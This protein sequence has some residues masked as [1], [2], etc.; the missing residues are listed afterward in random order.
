MR[1]ETDASPIEVK[2]WISNVWDH[3]PGN[4][5]DMSHVKIDHANNTNCELN[6]GIRLFD[7]PEAGD[8]DVLLDP[9][10][11][12][13][14][15]AAEHEKELQELYNGEAEDPSVYLDHGDGVDPDGDFEASDED[16]DPELDMEDEKA[17]LEDVDKDEKLGINEHE[18]KEEP[19][20][21]EN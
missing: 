17:F 9:S 19:D 7:L 3:V 16:A 13:K 4:H 14:A 1:N 20:N 18:G 6:D 11:D 12:K 15:A 2:E 10:E 5:F 21:D 8:Y